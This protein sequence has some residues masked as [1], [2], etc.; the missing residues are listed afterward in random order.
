MILLVKIIN[1][2]QPPHLYDI[3]SNY[4]RDANP[5]YFLRNN[6]I[7]LVYTRT[8]TFRRSFFPGAIR[9]WNNLDSEIR[10]VETVSLLKTKLKGNQL[11]KNSYYSLGSR[12]IN[13]ILSSIKLHCSQ[14]NDDL[15]K[16]DIIDNRYCVCG[17]EETPF[18]YFFQCPRY[19]AYR[20]RLYHET[21]FIQEL[22]LDIIL[23]G[24]NQLS[25]QENIILHETVS[26]FVQA[27]KRFQ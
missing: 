21:D 13:C 23:N 14:L 22:S 27:S 5:R 8:E 3:F 19:A 25:H 10:G 11:V 26:S 16:N 12:R 2:L 6:V 9:D 17:D 20:N 24:N 1:G 7:P 4:I 15:F 18:H